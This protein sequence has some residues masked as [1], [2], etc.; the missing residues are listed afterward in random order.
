MLACPVC[1]GSVWMEASGFVQ[2]VSILSRSRNLSQ[3][4]RFA[5]RAKAHRASG[6]NH[7]KIP[8]GLRSSPANLKNPVRSLFVQLRHHSISRRL[9]SLAP[10]MGRPDR[11]ARDRACEPFGFNIALSGPAISLSCAV[12]GGAFPLRA[13]VDR[14]RRRAHNS[15]AIEIDWR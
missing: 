2:A 9:A 8:S 12:D 10:S 15:A 6:P 1:C 13:I 5:E 3:Q 4:G 14:R 11:P 7:R